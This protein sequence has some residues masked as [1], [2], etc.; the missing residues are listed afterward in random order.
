[1]RPFLGRC[2][3]Q[4]PYSCEVLLDRFKERQSETVLDATIVVS[5]DSQKGMVIG[6]GGAKVKEVGI[7]ARIV[8]ARASVRLSS[9]V[10]GRYNN[11]GAA[12]AAGRDQA[13]MLYRAAES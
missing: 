1:M 7:K 10:T 6:K 12:G 9:E 2:A 5:Q 11:N 8:S 4:I 3:A 13:A